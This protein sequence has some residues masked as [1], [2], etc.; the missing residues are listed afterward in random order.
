MIDIL[1]T[2]AT[3]LIYGLAGMFL[4]LAGIISLC[5]IIYPFYLLFQGIRHKLL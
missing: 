5:A 2:V 4:V 1:P 3:W